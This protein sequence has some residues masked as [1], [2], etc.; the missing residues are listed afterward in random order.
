MKISNTYKTIIAAII[1]SVGLTS[2]LKDK[3]Y[4]PVQIAG[5]SLINTVPADQLLDVYADN[6]RTTALEFKFGTK[7]DYL[8][9]YAGSRNFT[10]TKFGL[11]QP[12]YS[13]RFTL[14]NQQGYSLF[15]IDKLENIKFLLL[16]DNLTK[17]AAGKAKVRFVHL[18]PDAAALDLKIVGSAANLFTNKIFKEYTEFEEIAAADDVDFQIKTA[19]GTVLATLADV[20]IEEGKIYTIYAKGLLANTDNTKFDAAIFTHK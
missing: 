15:V 13:E 1:L 18:S 11:T 6:N 9:A 4:E 12:L 17:P 7:I 8:N 5:L 2:C 16:K 19:T 20:K 10:V 3:D 14:E